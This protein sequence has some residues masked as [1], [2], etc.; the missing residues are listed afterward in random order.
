MRDSATIQN[1]LALAAVLRIYEAAF[2][3]DTGYSTQIADLLNFSGEHDFEVILLVAE[4][5]KDRH[6]GFALS[7]YFARQRTAY[8]DYIV[9]N[10]ARNARGYGSALYEA[11][12]EFLAQRKARGLC[13][14]VP[15]D[16]A[17]L[18]KE[19][20]RLPAN[21]RRLAFY[22]RLGA[23]PVIGT[24]YER[25]IRAANGGHG[26]YLVFD[27]LDTGRRLDGSELRAFLKRLLPAK[28]TLAIDD[29]R[30]TE[31]LKSIPNGPVQLREPAISSPSGI[32]RGRIRARWR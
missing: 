21:K 1:Q 30:L 6:L 28:G 15:A 18:L 3:D 29:P 32:A 13:M 4:G 11:T 27:D 17:E 25:I 14:D 23:R 22:E 20:E 10:P 16:D 5:R 9:S 2:P 24:A 12:C 31:L 7:F 8:L 26:T 19:K